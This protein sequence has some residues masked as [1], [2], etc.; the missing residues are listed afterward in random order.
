[1]E[2]RTHAAPDFQDDPAALN[3]RERASHLL[4]RLSY[5]ARP[6]EADKLIAMG[7]EAWLKDQLK[8]ADSRDPRLK[9][10]L[11]EYDTLGLTVREC[12]EFTFTERDRSKEQ[13]QEERRAERLKRRIPLDE[14]VWSTAL[15]AVYSNRQATEVM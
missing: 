15:R 2:L 5:G 1:M 12:A 6:G 10:W 14:V 8:Q 11:S 7:T 3:E 9:E 4:S 13:T